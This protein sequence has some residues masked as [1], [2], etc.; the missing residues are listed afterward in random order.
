MITLTESLNQS[1]KERNIKRNSI[2]VTEASKYTKSSI[3]SSIKVSNRGEFNKNI[4]VANWYDPDETI[5][6]DMDICFASEEDGVI[7]NIFEPD[8]KKYYQ[9]WIW[10]EK[11][12]RFEPLSEYDDSSNK[13]KE[14]WKFNN[15][16]AECPKYLTTKKLM[17]DDMMDS[18]F[19]NFV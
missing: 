2:P 15:F 16:K 10:K 14:V 11:D 9:D 7:V 19:G 3:F 18:L 1:L 12:H 8:G 4:P 5:E 6:I 13:P 17:D